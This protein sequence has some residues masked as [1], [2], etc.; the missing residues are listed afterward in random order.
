MSSVVRDR[1]FYVLL[2][3]YVW[4]SDQNQIKIISKFHKFLTLVY[5]IQI[6][7]YF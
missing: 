7:V 5:E 1:M 2:N 6:F 3:I 4:N